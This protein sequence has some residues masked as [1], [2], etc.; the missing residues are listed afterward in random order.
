MWHEYERDLYVFYFWMHTKYIFLLLC[1]IFDIISDVDAFLNQYSQLEFI[2]L[3]Y[4][5]YICIR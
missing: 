3:E 4:I 2:F 1:L 5:K